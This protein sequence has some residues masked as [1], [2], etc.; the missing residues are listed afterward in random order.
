M[1]QPNDTFEFQW[2]KTD[3]F[4]TI[5]KDEEIAKEVGQNGLYFISEKLDG[6]NMAICSDGY[7]A[8][9]QRII[10]TMDE[11]L[12]F[13]GFSLQHVL[14]LFEAVQELHEHLKT[15]FF[16]KHK[17]K[18]ILYGEF[19]HTGTA[20]SKF[21]IYTYLERGYEPGHHYAFGIGLIFD[22][23]TPEVD[24]DVRRVFRQAYRA[25]STKGEIFFL[26]PMDWFLTGLFYKLNI[27]CV[28]L[29][30][31]QSLQSVFAREDLMTPLLERHVEGYILASIS[32]QKMLK[33]KAMPAKTKHLD[34]HLEK[35]K[36]IHKPTLTTLQKIYDSSDT[37]FNVFDQ[38]TFTSYFNTV[39]TREKDFIEKSLVKEIMYD[40]DVFGKHMIRQTDRLLAII[41]LKLEDHYDKKLTPQVTCEMRLK[42]RNKL[43]VM[44][45]WFYMMNSIPSN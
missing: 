35:L 1:V 4:F 5:N 9:R 38:E 12:R 23:I 16:A 41:R 13:Q 36:D 45:R 31:V 11:A 25:T 19:M 30:S 2:S 24:R 20:N 37:F 14:P 18:V 15:A 32:G 10:A 43:R 22:A 33:L 7:I 27:E 8:S 29:H 3:G 21:D 34:E 17:F 42:I 40:H 28:R 44:T 39:F 6:S 26:V